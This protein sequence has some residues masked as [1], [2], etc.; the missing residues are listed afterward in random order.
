MLQLRLLRSWLANLYFSFPNNFLRITPLDIQSI[1]LS[2]VSKV[3]LRE[4]VFS[5]IQYVLKLCCRDQLNCLCFKNKPAEFASGYI[6]L[7]VYGL[8]STPEWFILNVQIT[9]TF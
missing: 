1:L 6:P 3:N 7:D 5:E 9:W 8:I 4:K 2:L